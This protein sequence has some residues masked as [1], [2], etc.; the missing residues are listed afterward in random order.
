M[1]ALASPAFGQG[2]FETA[3]EGE[4]KATTKLDWSGYVRGTVYGGSN[5]FDYATL[6]GEAGLQGR[7]SRGKAFILADARLREG[8]QF[9]ESAHMLQ[10][11]EA[12]AGYQSPKVD[13]FLGNQIVTWGRTDGFNPTNIITPKDY[14]FLTPDPDDQTL[15]NFMLRARY[16]IIPAIDLEV[17]AAP[18]YRPSSYRYDLFNLGEMAQFTEGSLPPQ[19][20]ENG[21]LSAKLNVELPGAGFSV[22]YFNGYEPFYGFNIQQIDLSNIL[23]PMIIYQ[24]AFYR[25]QAIGGDFAVP[26]GSWIARGEAAASFTKSYEAQMHVPNPDLYY[27]LGV[28]REFLGITGIFQYI[29]RYTFDFQELTAPPQENF[30]ERIQY[31]ST[32]INRKIFQQQEETNHALFLS[33]SRSFAHETLR[34]E[35]SAYYNITSEEYLVRP[36]ISWQISDALSATAGASIMGGPEGFI[37]DYAKDVLNGGFAQLKVSF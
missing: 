31:E 15:P 16:R 10:L 14:F 12:Y 1:A 5:Q 11:K 27:V 2:L 26:L 33:L 8:S 20:L 32:L 30:L 36:A 21:T 22:S 37:F 3:G 9:G 35:C 13:I 24:P 29:G 18:R 28:E 34:A 7:L 4:E 23:A 6:F 19:T 17:N 25:K